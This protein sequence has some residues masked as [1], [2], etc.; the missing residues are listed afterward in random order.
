M[1]IRFYLTKTAI[2]LVALMGASS[3]IAQEA[4]KEADCEMVKRALTV[5][6]DVSAMNRRKGA[7][8]NL[9]ELHEKHEAIGWSFDDLEIYIEDGDLEGFFVTYSRQGCKPA[10]AESKKSKKKR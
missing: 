6:Q 4:T 3:V 1:N 8:Q 5:F 2:C 7:G 10:K 9:T